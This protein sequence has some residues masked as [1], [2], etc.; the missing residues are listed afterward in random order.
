MKLHYITLSQ[1]SI[2]LLLSI[3]M[4]CTQDDLLD[5]AIIHYK[6]LPFIPINDITYTLGDVAE[7]S[8]STDT[9]CHRTIF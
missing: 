4:C 7:N 1:F 3:V 9:A 6:Q 8:L 5:D 2:N